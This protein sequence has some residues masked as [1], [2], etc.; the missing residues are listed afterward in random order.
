MR[1]YIINVG[2]IEE[3]QTV[4]DVSQLENIFTR[5]RSTIVN[6]EKVIL[7]RQNGSAAAEKFDELSTLS[8]LQQYKKQ[9]FKY[10]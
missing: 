9:V 8:D 7:V 10:L 3:L 4:G 2:K 1:E 6:G 5:A